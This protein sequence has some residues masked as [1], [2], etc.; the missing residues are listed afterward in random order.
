VVQYVDSLLAEKST[1]DDIEKVL[2]KVC[3]FLPDNLQQQ[4]DALVKT[5]GPTLIQ[6]ISQMMDPKEICTELGLCPAAAVPKPNG[7]VNLVPAKHIKHPLVDVVEAEKAPLLGAKECS[8]GPAYWCQS[9][10]NA[11]K[12]GMES[13]CDKHG[14]K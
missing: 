10:E 2:D 8:W 11:R 6:L 12:C 3:N 9:R 5:Y 7:L 13:H 14:Y 4:C 1:I